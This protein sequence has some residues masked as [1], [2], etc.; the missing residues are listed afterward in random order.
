M[1]TSLAQRLVS[2]WFNRDKKSGSFDMDLVR[3][4]GLYD[5]NQTDVILANKT[6]RGMAILEDAGEEL[7]PN[8]Y[9]IFNDVIYKSRSGIGS[10]LKVVGNAYIGNVDGVNDSMEEIAGF[11]VTIKSYL[12]RLKW[13]E[14]IASN[15]Y[16]ECYFESS[17]KN[18]GKKEY[19]EQ[20]PELFELEY[21]GSTSSTASETSFVGVKNAN[22]ALRKVCVRVI[23]RNIADLQKSFPNFRIKTPLLSAD[24]LVADVGLKESINKNS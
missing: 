6:V 9:V 3:K 2:K 20:H 17:E 7:I 8:T 16:K 11:Q 18:S 14:E 22:D 1:K 4:R 12:Y 15:F 23:D 13:N 19:Y 24:P 5:A 21:V 10:L